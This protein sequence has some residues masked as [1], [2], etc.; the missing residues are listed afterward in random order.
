MAGLIRKTKEAIG[1]KIEAFR[2]HEAL[3]ELWGLVSYGDGYLNDRKLW[4]KGDP[5]ALYTLVALLDN[6]AA[7]L[8]PF[9]P[10]A[11]ETITN[12]LVWRG[13]SLTARKP[14]PL[15]PRL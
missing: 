11:A 5:R 14:A 13:N 7:L 1:K 9:L 8:S 3:A 12:S 2:L 4:K 6:V 10:G 15:F